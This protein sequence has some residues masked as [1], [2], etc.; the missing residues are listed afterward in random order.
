MDKLNALATRRAVLDSR[1]AEHR[2]GTAVVRREPTSSPGT[3]RDALA[4]ADEQIERHERAHAEWTSM[5]AHDLR[6]PLGTIALST[7][8]LARASASDGEGTARELERIRWAVKSLARMTSDLLDASSIAAQ[9]MRVECVRVDIAALI[10]DA[11][12]HMPD[13]VERCDV[14]VDPGGDVL[15]HADPGRVEQVLANLLVN[16]AK[17]GEPGG[18]ITVDITRSRGE[19]RV[20]VSNRGPGIPAH[21]LSRVFERFERGRRT[22]KG[23]SGL[24]LGLYIAKQLIEAQG[25]RIW[26]KSAPGVITQLTFTLPLAARELVRADARRQL[27]STVPIR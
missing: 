22:R 16:A 10:R 4:S 25:G 17:Y 7:E 24:G 27:G 12:G 6:Q 13:L 14:H 18:T 23:Q 5:V 26:A 21:E 8:V 2:C 9:R 11:I 3:P 20:T 15:V 19:A 1:D